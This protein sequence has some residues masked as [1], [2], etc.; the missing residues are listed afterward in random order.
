MEYKI[1]FLDVDGTLYSHSTS[2]IPESTLLAIRKA[3]ENGILCF[4]CTGR[5]MLEIKDLHIPLDLLDGWITLN[6][7]LCLYKNETYFALPVEKEDLQI[8]VEEE[9]KHPF[10]I[11]FLT[12]EKML[13]NMYDEHV[14]K[15]LDEIHSVYPEILDIHE[16]L[17]Q[18]IYQCIPYAEESIWHP[19]FLKLKHV[20]ATRWTPLAIDVINRDAGKDRGIQETLKYFHIRKEEAIAIG[21]DINDIP[22]MKEVGCS[23]AMGNAKQELKKICDFETTEIDN[24]GIYHAF[25]SAGII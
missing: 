7:S 12:K 14:K 2:C 3:R 18:N 19:L 17:K 9:M 25:Q 8:L 20:Q 10:P 22:M 6:G 23:F 5:H 1:V 13:I 24:Y 4:A 16:C 11:I 21:D 15:E